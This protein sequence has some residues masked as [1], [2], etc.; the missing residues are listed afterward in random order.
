[1]LAGYQEKGCL[2]GNFL[3]KCVHPT[4]DLDSNVPACILCIAPWSGLC[5]QWR[6]CVMEHSD[7]S[8][9]CFAN[10]LA[11][12]IRGAFFS[13]VRKIIDILFLFGFVFAWE[14]N[15]C[16]GDSS[17]EKPMFE[18]SSFSATI[19][20]FSAGEESW[21]GVRRPRSRPFLLITSCCGLVT[22]PVF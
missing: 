17:P 3:N 14:E 16:Q 19:T 12:W 9:L 15:V 6:D 7:K 22:V 5:F 18:M 21:G 2:K 11:R 4:W 1:M 13:Q 8:P 10:F 20:W